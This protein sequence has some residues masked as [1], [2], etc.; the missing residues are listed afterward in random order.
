[1]KLEGVTEMNKNNAESAIGTLERLRRLWFN[2][3][4]AMDVVGNENTEITIRLLKKRIPK[5]PL[6]KHYEEEGE[7]PYTKYCCP[8]GCRVQFH[9]PRKG[10]ACETF[11]CHKCGQA[12]DWGDD[13]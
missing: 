5:K 3:H 9:P 4:G 13:E 2:V 11:Y 10:L 1:M 6:E 12:I 7:P 8:N